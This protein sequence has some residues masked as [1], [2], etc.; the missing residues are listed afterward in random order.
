[1]ASYTLPHFGQLDTSNLEEY[2]DVGIEFNGKK[3]QI[4]LNFENKSIEKKRIDLVRKF[5]DNIVD[6]DKKNTKYIELD[7]DDEE[8]DTIKTYVAHHLGE[9]SKDDLI[10]LVDFNNKSIEPEKQLI[11][12]LH[13][14]RVGLYPGNENQ[15]AIFDY[16]IGR[17][18]TDYLVVIN[19]DE[20]GNLDYMTMES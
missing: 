18:L 8:C 7:Y 9:I 16:S 3:I 15:F 11:K 13:L 5:L 12:A 19:T 1:M 10:D 2:Y 14:V 4:D 20:K 17:D 6:F